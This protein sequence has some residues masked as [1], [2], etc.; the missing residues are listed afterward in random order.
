MRKGAAQALVVLAVLVSLLTAVGGVSAAENSLVRGILIE[1]NNYVDTETIR[2]A[3]VKTKLNEPATEQM[4]LD[5]LHSIFDLGY[6]QDASVKLEPALGGVQVVFQVIENPIV[7]QINFSGLS[8][9][10]LQNYM[11]NMKTQIGYIL[12]VHD[13]GEDLYYM[14]EWIALEHGYL[15]RVGSLEGDTDGRIFIEWVP[16]VIDRKSV[17]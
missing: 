12:N 6:F 5:D 15:A 10:P 9:V 4:L 14:R 13:L 11:K 16:T 8:Q 7:S 2:A 3:I 17:V 1:G